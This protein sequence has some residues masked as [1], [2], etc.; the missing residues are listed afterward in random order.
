MGW[1][2]VFG[3]IYDP[4]GAGFGPEA[5]VQEIPAELGETGKG[6]GMDPAS[7]QDVGD[8]DVVGALATYDKAR[9]L[10]SGSGLTS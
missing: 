2:Q 9:L 7:P 8:L 3:G 1:E 5:G 4:V 10:E 6:I